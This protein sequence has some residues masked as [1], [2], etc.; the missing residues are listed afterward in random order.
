MRDV[1]EALRIAPN[2]TSLLSCRGEVYFQSG[3]FDKSIA[4]HSKA[5]ALGATESS[6]FRSRG[7]AR[8][9]AGRLEEAAADYVKASE[10]ADKESRIY[11][12]IWVAAI[13]GRLGKPVPDAIIKSAAAEA[14]GEWP[15]PALAVVT[16]AMPPAEMLKRIDQKK[17]DERDMALA[18]GYF[19]LGQRYL[20]VGD[21]K[22]AQS[23]FEKARQ[24]GVFT[25][26]EH[27]AA[28]FELQQLAKASPA[29]AAAPVAAKPVVTKPPPTPAGSA[30]PPPG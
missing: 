23:Y 4:D 19:Y 18:E 27:M 17:G 2:N 15:R 12:D 3:Q 5:V 9:Y 22:T 24:V 21:K 1:N 20:V 13:Y 28:A 10:L 25:Y 11:C 26:T 30:Q 14:A 29:A 16:G 7:T 8:L 6:V